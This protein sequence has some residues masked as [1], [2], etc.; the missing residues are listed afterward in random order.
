[1]RYICI[2]QQDYSDCG[3]AAL[4]TVAKHFKLKIPISE[5]REVAGTDKVGTNAYGMV[6]A[7]EELGF[8]AKAVKGDPS[9]FASEF[10]LPAIAMV[11]NEN[12][13]MHYV[14]IY[15]KS[16]GK[17]IVADP[18]K[19]I[20]TYSTEEFLKIWLGILIL[21][22]P[23]PDF[24][25]GDK[26]KNFLLSFFKLLIPQK[27]LL[28]FIFLA[29][30]L[31]T[32][33]GILAAFY[34]RLIMDTI[35]P[36]AL[37]TMLTTVSVG[38]IVLY[39]V[40][41]VIE[42]FR[43]HLTLYLSQKLDIPLL[44]GYYK[45]VIGLPM[46][47]FGTRKVGEIVSRF[48]D[49][50]KIRDAISG[51]TLTMMIDVIMAI[52]GGIILY[53]QDARLFLIAL[54]MVIIYA[55]VVFAFNRPIR[56]INEKMMENN[57]QLTSYL[58][59]SIEGIETI[60]V[61]NNESTARAKTDSLFVRLLRSVFKGGF[62]H[63]TQGAISGAIAAIGTTAILWVGTLQVI[64]GNL[65]LG[66]LITFNA[67]LLYFIDPVRNIIN[68]QPQ[69]QTAVVAANRL[70]EIL[71]LKS[72]EE[73]EALGKLNP[74]SLKSDIVVEDVS[75]RYGTRRLVLED[76]NLVIPMGARVALVGESGSGKTSLANLLT[77]LY[78]FEKGD[79]RFGNY[80]IK[81]IS[82]ETLRAKVGYVPQDPHF[83]SGPIRENLMLG[84]DGQSME[85][86]TDACARV[87]A[88]DFINKL[89][90]RYETYLEENAANLSGGQRQ[91]LAIA[92]VLMREPDILILDEATSHLDS[93][94]E[95]VI[96]D[97]IA[98]MPADVSVLLIAHRLSSIMHC[99]LICVMQDGRIVESGS[100]AELMAMG[101]HYWEL[102]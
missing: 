46:S 11:V 34:F 101:G 80:N 17:V 38:I 93:N 65:T 13:Q 28:V 39:A 55:I 23:S 4:A 75:F 6:K 45:H 98:L 87:G 53:M 30:V 83:F 89:P 94:S 12:L 63:N 61:S 20:V 74:A 102:W 73:R 67:L 96:R 19:G 21:L 50:S 15:K 44:L 40:K 79:I 66:E 42:F 97:T 60:K 59:E 99:D 82:L 77:R 92:R 7:A 86:M 54:I 24:I 3:A 10:T 47:F 84:L 95:A 1:M 70:G 2:K 37:T 43:N 100:H 68:L 78:E 5:I 71:S 35:V 69:L 48:M 62:I 90:M 22:T 25:T 31:I 81:D 88:V 41:A 18:A 9:A 57:A 16:D 64:N 51:A 56:S 91:K 85:K 52:I 26:T 27:R 49:A 29:S 32:V 58:V 33:F 14:V 36:G 76:I 8:Y 72:E